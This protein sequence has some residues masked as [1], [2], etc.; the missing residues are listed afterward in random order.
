MTPKEYVSIYKSYLKDNDVYYVSE[1]RAV[2]TKKNYQIF[3][4]KPDL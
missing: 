1:H 3:S 2:M 4:L